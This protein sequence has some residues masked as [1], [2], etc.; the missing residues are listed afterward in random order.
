MVELPA[1]APYTFTNARSFNS[2]SQVVG[3]MLNGG[4]EVASLW[5]GTTPQIL[6]TL[7]G[8]TFSSAYDINL[9]GVVVGGATADDGT[10]VPFVWT[11]SMQPLPGPFSHDVVTAVSINDSGQIVGSGQSLVSSSDRQAYYWPDANSSAQILPIPGDATGA[12]VTKI[13]VDGTIIGSLSYFSAPGDIACVWHSPTDLPELLSPLDGYDSSYGADRS[14][15]GVVVGSCSMAGLVPCIWQ[16]GMVQAL[17][18]PTEGAQGSADAVNKDGLIVGRAVFNAAFHATKWVNN[19]PID[20]NTRV[21]PGSPNWVLALASDVNDYGEILG[22]GY[23]NGNGRAFLA[24]PFGSGGQT[25]LT[26]NCSVILS[27]FVG[28]AE[29]V[30]ISVDL[31]RTMDGSHYGPYTVYRDPGTGL[32][33]MQINLRGQFDVVAKGPHWLASRAQNVVISNLGATGA[34]FVLINGDIDQDNA[35][36]VFDYGVLSDYFDKASGDEDWTTVG[37]NGFAP[38]DADVDGDEAVTVFDYGI[39]S[40]NFDRTGDD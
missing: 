10:A 22:Y 27:D 20:L 34:N 36:T 23:H 30:P 5:N 8:Y 26:V 32:Y 15:S 9:M 18:L 1:L 24:T 3:S 40:D 7:P 33:P 25:G 21:D 38:K 29:S 6:G 16:S 39:I 37:P 19:I 12:Q 11:G 35:V 2:A 17:T 28:A 13:L 14:P 4:G 31:Y